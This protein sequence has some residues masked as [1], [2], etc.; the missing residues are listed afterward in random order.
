[1]SAP[2]VLALEAARGVGERL[3]LAGLNLTLSEGDFAMIEVPGSRR[4]AAFADLCSGLAAVTAGCVRF[5]G[6]DWTATPHRHADALRGHIGRLFHLPLRTDTPDVALRVLAARLHHTRTPEATLRAE[7][8]ALALRFGLPGLPAGPARQLTQPDLLRAACV[9][10][11][12]G[13][14]R[15]LILEL[16][17][18]AQQDDLLPALL[19]AGAEARGRGTTVMWLAGP[20]PAARDRSIRATHRLRLSDAG[21]APVRLLTRPA[22]K[23]PALIRPALTGPALTGPVLSGTA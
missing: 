10:A 3:P 1:V 12:L 18:T 6:R 13:Q 16:P 4:G 14:P 8:T 17:V 15:L 20:G 7:A 21:L 22:P 23:G 19:E 2:P 11:F 9:R 5:L